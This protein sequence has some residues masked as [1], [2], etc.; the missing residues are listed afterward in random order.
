MEILLFPFQKRD[1]REV[2]N[3]PNNINKLESGRFEI[4]EFKISMTLKKI[5][6]TRFETKNLHLE[7]IVMSS[8]GWLGE[9]KGNST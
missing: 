5:I 2:I 1:F 3:L 8:Y 6:H 7:N 9:M 4:T